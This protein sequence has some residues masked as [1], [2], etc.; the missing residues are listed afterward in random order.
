MMVVRPPQKGVTDRSGSLR[1]RPL[2]PAIPAVGLTAFGLRLLDP[3]SHSFNSRLF[4]LDRFRKSGGFRVR[5]GSHSS[6]HVH[7]ALL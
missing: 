6:A 2:E 7:T 4:V 1:A 3:Q 5:L